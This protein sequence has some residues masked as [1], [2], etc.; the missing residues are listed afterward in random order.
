MN[1]LFITEHDIQVSFDAESLFNRNQKHI[2]F[3]IFQKHRNTAD[4]PQDLPV[5]TKHCGDRENSTDKSKAP[6]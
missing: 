5:L 1:E 6:Q 4:V 2:A 3:E